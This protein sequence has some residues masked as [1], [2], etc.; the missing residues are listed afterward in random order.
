S[1]GR[2]VVDDVVIAVGRVRA[3]V[4]VSVGQR[5]GR[6]QPRKYRIVENHPVYA[7]DEIPHRVTVVQRIDPGVKDEGIAVRATA[8]RVVPQSTAEMVVAGITPKRVV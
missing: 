7:G 3:D 8:E 6:R 1:A 4:E 2:L 5:A